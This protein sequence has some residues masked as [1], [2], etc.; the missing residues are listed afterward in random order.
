MKSI[1][2]DSRNT[3]AFSDSPNCPISNLAIMMNRK[4]RMGPLKKLV[5]PIGKRLGIIRAS[6]LSR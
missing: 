5:M 3:R 2:L 4:K 6:R 1:P